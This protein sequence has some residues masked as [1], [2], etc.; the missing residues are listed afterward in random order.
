MCL[1][2]N[3]IYGISERR[4][5]GPVNSPYKYKLED[6]EQGKEVVIDR[7]DATSLKGK[8]LKVLEDGCV[9]GVLSPETDESLLEVFV[10]YEHIRGVGST[11]WNYDVIAH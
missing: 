6:F 11:E 3:Q 1:Q 5:E 4:K 7:A 9:V 8:L 2:I 10:A